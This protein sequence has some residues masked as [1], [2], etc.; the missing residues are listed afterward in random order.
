MPSSLGFSCSPEQLQ[1]V[2]D[3]VGDG[4]AAADVCSRY[5]VETLG[6]Q[7]AVF[8]YLA[9]SKEQGDIDLQNSINT[10]FVLFS[11]YMVFLMQAG[12]ALVSVTLEPTKPAIQDCT[13]GTSSTSSQRCQCSALAYCHS[14]C[15]NRGVGVTGLS[16]K[17]HF[18]LTDLASVCCSYVLGM[19][20]SRTT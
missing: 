19:C 14:L 12:F 3:F 8:R 10:V 16:L 2:Q 13:T 15:G 1:A 4:N 11:G 5:D 20:V 17:L 18:V 9:Q 7:R 6:A